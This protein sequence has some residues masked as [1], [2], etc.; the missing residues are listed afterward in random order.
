[1]RELSIYVT[2]IAAFVED[3]RRAIAVN[4]LQPAAMEVEGKLVTVPAHF[5]YVRLPF[6][7]IVDPENYSISHDWSTSA[8]P[9]IFPNVIE[10]TLVKFLRFHEVILPDSKTPPTI[11][12]TPLNATRIPIRTATPGGPPVDDTSV[13]WLAPMEFLTSASTI[14]P[15]HVVENPGEAVAAYVRFPKGRISTASPTSFKFVSVSAADGTPAGQLDQAVAQLMVCRL[16]VPEE[17]FTVLCRDYRDGG[18]ND[19]AINFTA[20][21]QNI[22]MV[23]ACTSLEDALQLPSVEDQF[24]VDTHFTLVYRLAQSVKDD[25]VVLPKSLIPQENV[26]DPKPLGAGRCVPPRFKGGSTGGL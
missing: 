20:G 6:D 21:A 2:G 12:D 14:D 23:F 26:G 10:P 11:D 17:A 24:G 7:Q 9:G 13:L 22:W 16:S 25:D 5:P 8:A 15:Q 19:F 18:K 4:A 1:M 3:Y